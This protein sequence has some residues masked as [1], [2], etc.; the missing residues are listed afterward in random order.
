MQHQ[1]V[2]MCSAQI[3]NNAATFNKTTQ[4]QVAAALQNGTF[5]GS[6][7]NF[8]QSQKLHKWAE[9]TIKAKSVA[10]RAFLSFLQATGLD[11]LAAAPMGDCEN[12]TRATK[13]QEEETLCAFAFLRVMTGQTPTGSLQYVS[14]VRQWYKFNHQFNFGYPGNYGNPSFTSEA[15]KSL[16]PFFDNTDSTD[17]K[18]KPITK[19]ILLMLTRYATARQMHDLATAMVLAW[20]GLF[21]FGEL[22]ETPD[23][24]F[25]TKNGMSEKNVKFVPSLWNCTH[26]LVYCGPSKADQSGIRGKSHPRMLPYAEDELNAARRLQQHFMRRFNSDKYSPAAKHRQHVPLFMRHDGKQLQMAHSLKIMREALTQAGLCG[27]DYGTH[28][29]RIG[30]FNHY[31]KMKVPIEIIKTIGGWSSDAWREYLRLQQNECMQYTK[32]MTKD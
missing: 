5:M 6:V 26:V 1:P 30:G 12:K 20:V 29:L 11:S 16:R 19:E 18:R 4:V 31:F 28:S 7:A 32:A 22:T 15:V 17:T 2:H 23:K 3:A 27:Q 14:H 10:V 24:Q 13:L 21:R 25:S 9:G 8:I